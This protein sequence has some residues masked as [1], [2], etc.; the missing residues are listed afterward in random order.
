MADNNGIKLSVNT[1]EIQLASEE[2]MV[3]MEEK[4]RKNLDWLLPNEADRLLI[5][6]ALGL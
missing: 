3:P 1:N 4:A 2:A 5:K 6:D